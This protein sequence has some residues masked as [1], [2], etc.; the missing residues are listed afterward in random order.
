MSLS[1]PRET[2]PEDQNDTGTAESAQVTTTTTTTDQTASNAD[3]EASGYVEH[4]FVLHMCS[5][6]A[7]RTVVQQQSAEQILAGQFARVGVLFCLSDEITVE[8][9]RRLRF[10][11]HIPLKL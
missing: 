2:P 1:V 7:F 3:A 6:F 8:L 10:K 9:F 4:E 11:M 5:P